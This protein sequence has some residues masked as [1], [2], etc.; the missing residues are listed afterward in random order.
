M[1]QMGNTINSL[2]IELV[3]NSE[4]ALQWAEIERLPTFER[5]R[6]SLFDED[7]DH[8]NAIDGEGK[9]VID[10]TKLGD[11]ERRNFIEKLIKHVE[12]DNLRLLKKIRDR[13]DKQ[14]YSHFD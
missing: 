13:M 5:L 6:S 12:D 11:L 1:A 9:K 2:G 10:V 8:R 4:Y 14:V 7:D 3:D